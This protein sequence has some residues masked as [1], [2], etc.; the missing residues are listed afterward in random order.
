MPRQP[1]LARVY[2]AALTPLGPDLSPDIPRLVAHCRHLLAAGC[3]GLGVLG[4]TGEATS[5]SVAERIA[6]MDGLVAAGIAA[7]RLIPGTGCAALPDTVALTKAAMSLG[8]RGVLVL[9]PFYYKGVPDDGLFAAYAAL[10]ERTRGEVA[11]YLYNFPQTTG[12]PLSLGL[13]RRL[14]R[15]FP[16]VV[17]G[18]KDSSGDFANM[19]AMIA[20]FGPEGFEVYSG[21]D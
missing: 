5:F 7:E 2:A 15:A 19:R 6:V 13:I 21:S 10:I 1:S 9:P 12:L 11:I 17:R 20:E 4:S 16:G 3:D 14:L 8:I 18:I